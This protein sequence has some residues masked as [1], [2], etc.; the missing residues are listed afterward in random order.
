[1]L[2]NRPDWIFLDEAASALD[3]AAE[4]ELLSMLAAR[5][6]KA[7]F[8]IAAHRR[9]PGLSGLREFVIGGAE[10]EAGEDLMRA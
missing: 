1:L 7:A 6:P 8:I 10:D 9:P 2:L 5:L 3:D 4:A